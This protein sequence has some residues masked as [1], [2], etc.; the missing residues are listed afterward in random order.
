[1]NGDTMDIKDYW[2]LNPPPENT[3]EAW[4]E[5]VAMRLE[6]WQGFNQ[7]EAKEGFLK[8]G[9]PINTKQGQEM[10][11]IIAYRV[12]EELAESF[13][14][15][16]SDHAYEELIDAFNY[17][18]GIFL[19]GKS[20]APHLPRFLQEVSE[21]SFSGTTSLHITLR[22]L[23]EATVIL[24]VQMGDLLRNRAWM[25]QAQSTYFD[26]DLSGILRP[27][28]SLIFRLFPSF[29]A[30]WSYYVAKD[31]VLQFRLRSNY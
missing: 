2:P 6:T 18:L 28:F 19:M 20:V 29:G 7:R 17:L 25:Q 13:D 1:M 22:H 14:S 12:L 26:G 11:R 15:T 23:G 30:F 31:A 10:I 16:D 3:V 4:N 21:E 8:I 5:M 9:T 27:L 24:G